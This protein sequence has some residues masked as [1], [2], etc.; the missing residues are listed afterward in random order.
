MDN[1]T[2]RA[3]QATLRHAKAE[4]QR[5]DE[6]RHLV[7]AAIAFT[8]AQ[9]EMAPESS[10]PTQRP[11]SQRPTRHGQPPS[12]V[13]AAKAALDRAGAPLTSNELFTRVA[14]VVGLKGKYAKPTFQRA[15]RA[16]GRFVRDEEGRWTLREWAQITPLPTSAGSVSDDEDGGD[17]DHQ[18]DNLM[19]GT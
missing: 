16:D 9:L 19:T 11:H 4:L 17:A 13:D 12:S 2:R 15:V 3:L 10:E 8:S 5:L 14:R 7:M 6:Q 18:E 1:S